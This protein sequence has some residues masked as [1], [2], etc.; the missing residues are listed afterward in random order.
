MTSRP[1]PGSYCE[2]EF[3]LREALALGIRVGTDGSE[4]VMLVPARVPWATV[5][6]FEH[7]LSNRQHEIVDY[8]LKEN[9]AQGGEF[10]P[11]RS[12]RRR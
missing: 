8:I 3:L 2:A 12:R 5:R 9:A 10:V 7:E 1:D 4:L 11:D 6:W